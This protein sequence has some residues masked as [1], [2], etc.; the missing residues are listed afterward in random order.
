MMIHDESIKKVLQD[1]GWY[2]GR[3]FDITPYLEWYQKYGLEAPQVVRD[4]LT[5]AGYKV[6]D[7]I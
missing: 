5:S 6:N 4:F 3:S 7:D 2:E 1:S